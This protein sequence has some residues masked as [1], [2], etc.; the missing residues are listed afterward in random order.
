MKLSN[1]FTTMR[2]VFAPIFFLLYNIPLWTHSE[3]LCKISSFIMLPLLAIFELTDYFDGYFARKNGEVSDFGKLFDPFA[4]VILNLTVF[5]C[6]TQ[7]VS[8]KISTY[9]PL[10]IFVFILYREFSMNFIRMIAVS[11]G[12]AIAARKG[13]KIKTVFYITSGFFAL[14]I[15]SLLRLNIDLPYLMQFKVVAVILF[16]I[17]LLLSYISFIDY[18]KTFCKILK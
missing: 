14:L 3:L 2:L 16:S 18:I 10:V 8:P 1:T 17:C 9:M 5:L 4:D 12:V 6:A 7:S 13:G 11:K 15:E